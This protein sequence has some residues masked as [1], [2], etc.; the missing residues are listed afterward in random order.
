M[1]TIYDIFPEPFRGMIRIVDYSTD[2]WIAAGE[3]EQVEELMVVH[4]YL[5]QKA[6]EQVDVEME[7]EYNRSIHKEIVNDTISTS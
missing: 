7:E 4:D 5:V 3:M 1:I 2:L 6:R